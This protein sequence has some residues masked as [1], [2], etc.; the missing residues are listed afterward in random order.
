MA[1]MPSPPRA[2][3]AR[4]AHGSVAESVQHAVFDDLPAPVRERFV[5]CA[6]GRA[7]PAPLLTAIRQGRVLPYALIALGCAVALVSLLWTGWGIDPEAERLEHGGRVTATYAPFVL[8]FCASIVAALREHARGESLPWAPGRYLFPAA[9]VDA[10]SAKLRIVSLMALR[11]SRQ[12][13]RPGRRAIVLELRFEGGNVE[14]IP[15]DPAAPIEA[16]AIKKMRRRLERAIAASDESALARLDPF[17]IRPQDVELVG[18]YRRS[19]GR[20]ASPSSAPRTR[21]M[22]RWL[23][24]PVLLTAVAAIALTAAL[25]LY[26]LPALAIATARDAHSSAS[27]RRVVRAWPYGWVERAAGVRAEGAAESAAEL[28]HRLRHPDALFVPALVKL[29]LDAEDRGEHARVPS[30]FQLGSEASS[31]A[32]P[33]M[34]DE[35]QVRRIVVSFER[36]LALPPDLF[37]LE[38]RGNLPRNPQPGH[39]LL[40]CTLE[41]SKRTYEVRGV[42][43]PGLVLACEA[44]LTFGQNPELMAK[45]AVEPSPSLNLDALVEGDAGATWMGSARVYATMVE[46]AIE[47]L[48]PAFEGALYEEP[49]AAR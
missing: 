34:L 49:G 17:A 30:Y 22:P 47:G 2:D 28:R 36:A 16:D 10:T 5:A 46:S 4:A 1:S 21:A 6:D 15:Q 35:E 45:V 18:D 13:Q 24:R 37:A 12:V 23:G 33:V 42:S 8:A 14:T 39:L 32:S 48:T 44:W 25:G 31:D 40:R 20:V 43:Q 29:L 41:P 26:A 3:T 9:F 11:S 7:E 27:L 38:V 19:S